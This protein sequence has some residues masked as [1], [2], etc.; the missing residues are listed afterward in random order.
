VIE[1]GPSYVLD[2]IGDLSYGCIGEQC[3][4]SCCQYL[5]AGDPRLRDLFLPRAQLGLLNLLIAELQRK[6]ICASVARIAA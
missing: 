6:G 4:L 3:N 1:R 2:E 5:A